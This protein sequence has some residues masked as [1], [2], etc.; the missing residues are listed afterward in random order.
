M[1]ALKYDKTKGIIWK[2][3]IAELSL[4]IISSRKVQNCSIAATSLFSVWF[5]NGN[6]F[7]M[8]M[9]FTMLTET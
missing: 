2:K 4:G 7:A 9:R 3:M 8:D 5:Q 1:D 6:V